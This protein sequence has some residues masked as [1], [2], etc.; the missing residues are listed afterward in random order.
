MT[1]MTLKQPITH[2]SALTHVAKAYV[3]KGLGENEA[4]WTRK[5]GIRQVQLVA[6]C[7]AVF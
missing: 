2:P 7:K 6:A 1:H 3:E 4:E 5:E